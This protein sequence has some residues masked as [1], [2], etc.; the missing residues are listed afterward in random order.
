MGK[1]VDE[2]EFISTPS[3]SMD[4]VE[5][6]ALVAN[7]PWYDDTQT[8]AYGAGSLATAEN[9]KHWLQAA[10]DEKTDHVKEIH[11][12]HIRRTAKRKEQKLQGGHVG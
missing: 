10:I 5:A 9:G 11:E 7:P 6:G 3:Y 2:V 12:Q 1:V 4:W 8:G